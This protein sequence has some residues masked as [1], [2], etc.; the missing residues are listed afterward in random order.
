MKITRNK[1]DMNITCKELCTLTLAC[2]FTVLAGCKEGDV[3]K[4]Q[5]DVAPGEMTVVS[6][7]PLTK[8]EPESTNLIK[9]GR[10][11]LFY[12]GSPA[13]NYFYPA[14]NET[15]SYLKKA[16][17]SGVHGDYSV[18]QYWNKLDALQDIK[19]HFHTEVRGLKPQTVY[20]LD[21]FAKAYT[22]GVAYVSVWET[23]GNA[24][25][26]LAQNLLAIT[27]GQEAGEPYSGT[28]K[29]RRGGSVVIA[30]HTDMEGPTPR[31]GW[32]EF[33]LREAPGQEVTAPELRGFNHLEAK[34]TET[35]MTLAHITSFT[36]WKG[37]AP[38]GWVLEH[39]KVSQKTVAG[40][41]V[42][43]FPNGAGDKGTRL[44]LALN[45]K[46]PIKGTK[47]RVAMDIK[48]SEI[49]RISF[50]VYGLV[51][52][53]LQAISKENPQ[54]TMWQ[55]YNGRGEWERV[56]YTMNITPEMDLSLVKVFILHRNNARRPAYVTNLKVEVLNQTK[57]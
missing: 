43:L 19:D 49:N 27:K 14:K 16:S 7:T 9:N 39:G 5:I 20:A 18:T 15:Y 53:K 48:S 54:A 44:S 8:K 52:G 51:T 23:K 29:T 32:E 31:V 22:G 36:D 34:Q 24:P 1:V 10:F 41:T 3:P 57:G 47:L 13:P 6:V 50:S 25:Q 30:A 2:V 42:L 56:S 33:I 46:D 45:N 17:S 38:T 12:T 37:N 28:F 35:G 26:V 21:V 4:V 40:G 55:S 11:D